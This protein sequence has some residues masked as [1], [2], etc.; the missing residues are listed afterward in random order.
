MASN[1]STWEIEDWLLLI[2]GLWLINKVFKTSTQAGIGALK[3][4]Q[5]KLVP[6][7]THDGIKAFEEDMKDLSSDERN[8][9]KLLIIKARLIPLLR[10]PYYKSFPS[11]NF[12]N[13]EFRSK[14]FRIFVKSLAN[15]DFLML[16]F[17]IKKTN[18]TPQDEIKKAEQRA[19]EFSRGV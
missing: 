15:G 17:F 11:S 2:G 12:I 10:E 8:E 14:R 16:S 5:R 6:Y 13:G 4:A 9:L 7:I 19:K 18:K 3:D 1:K